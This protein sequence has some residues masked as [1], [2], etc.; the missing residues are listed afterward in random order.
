MLLTNLNLTQHK[1]NLFL[2]FP[3]SS[4]QK[5]QHEAFFNWTNLRSILT[6]SRCPNHPLSK[7]GDELEG[8]EGQGLKERN[9]VYVSITF[10][11]A[12]GQP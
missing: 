6:S 1:R 9:A 5:T 12:I 10:L 3:A 7:E 4:K 8:R 11:D 2:L